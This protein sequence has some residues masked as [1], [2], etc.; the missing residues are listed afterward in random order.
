MNENSVVLKIKHPS[1]SYDIVY[2]F[3]QKYSN[4]TFHTEI[5]ERQKYAEVSGNKLVPYVHESLPD[6][7]CVLMQDRTSC[8]RGRIIPMP[9]TFRC[10]RGIP[11]QET[12]I[13]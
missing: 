4:Y 11:V 1:K 10:C 5:P 12:S 2:D 7:N 3:R 6:G 8:Y 9:M 13:T